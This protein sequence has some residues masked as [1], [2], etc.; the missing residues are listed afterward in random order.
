MVYSLEIGLMK[1]NVDLYKIRF[2][3]QK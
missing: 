3:S 1:N 2:D